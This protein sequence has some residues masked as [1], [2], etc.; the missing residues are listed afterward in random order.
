MNSR[1]GL[2]LIFVLA[3]LVCGYDAYAAVRAQ[4]HNIVAW[5]LAAIMALVALSALRKLIRKDYSNSWW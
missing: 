1:N 4:G 3:A 5:A 2:T